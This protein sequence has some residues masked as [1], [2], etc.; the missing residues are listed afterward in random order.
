[1]SKNLDRIMAQ[2]AK[3]HQIARDQL[4]LEAVVS[5]LLIDLGTAE[6]IERLQAEINLLR[7][8]G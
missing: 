8:V 6:T 3:D 1:M 5:L 7:E 4:M 2:A